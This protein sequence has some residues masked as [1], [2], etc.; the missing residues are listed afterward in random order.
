MTGEGNIQDWGREEHSSPASLG[1]GRRYHQFPSCPM[2]LPFH[3]ERPGF[4]I[5]VS[6][7]E[8][9]NLTTAQAGGQLQQEQLVAAILSGLD[10]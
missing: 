2:D 9:A 4:E 10:Q 7:L 3:L 5:Q 8:G 6:P 1:F